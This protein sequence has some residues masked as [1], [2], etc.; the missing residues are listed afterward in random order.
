MFFIVIELNFRVVNKVCIIISVLVLIGS[1]V[2]A[3]KSSETLVIHGLQKIPKKTLVHYWGKPSS[4]LLTDH[5]KSINKSIH[6]L[7]Q[8]G[9]FEDVVVTDQV[10]HLVVSVKERPVISQVEFDDYDALKEDKIKEWLEE[11]GLEKSSFYSASKRYGLEEKIKRYYESLGRFET[12][13]HFTVAPEKNNQVSLKLN[14]DESSVSSIQNIHINGAKSFSES[15]V[16]KRWPIAAHHFFS[17][18]TGTDDYIK[19]NVAQ[20]VVLLEQFYHDRGYLDYELKSKKVNFNKEDGQ[21]D[22]VFNIDEGQVYTINKCVVDEGAKQI[23]A[24]EVQA[25]CSD[26]VNKIYKEKQISEK[27]AALS[28]SLEKEHILNY[29]YNL[30]KKINHKKH[31]VAVNIS[32]REAQ[33]D[34]VRHINIHGNNGMSDLILRHALGFEEAGV[35]S[36]E[37]VKQSY[38]QLMMLGFVENI[39]FQPIPVPGQ[40]HLSDLD[41]SLQEKRMVSMTFQVGWGSADGFLGNIGFNNGNFLGLGQK[42]SFQLKY[43]QISQVLSFDYVD[44]YYNFHHGSRSYGFYLK[45]QTPGKRLQHTHYIKDATGGYINYG[46]PLNRYAS[47]NYGAGINYNT[48]KEFQSASAEIQS[49]IQDHGDSYQEY[50]VSGGFTYNTLN[51]RFFASKGQDLSANINFRLPLNKYS[52]SYYTFHFDWGLYQKLTH[53]YHEKDDFVFGFRYQFDYGNH[54]GQFKDYPFYANFYAG[55]LSSIKGFQAGSLGPKDSLGNVF[56]GNIAHFTEAQVLLP[57]R[58]FGDSFRVSYFVDA[59]QVYL[60]NMALKDI[61]MSTGVMFKWLTPLCPITMSYALPIKS[62]PGDLLDRFQIGITAAF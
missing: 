7:Y 14:L 43:S 19:D 51:R 44:P 45:R 25:A 42:L 29:Q 56:G 13:V 8:T 15:E 10:D 21:V 54:Y 58:W 55:G 57:E 37:K 60:K 17:F 2:A 20:A 36:Q 27:I 61:R 49:F 62:R 39:G 22:I 34:Y 9:F 48:I 26:M 28:R 53:F 31:T 32:K 4:Y 6:Q 46:Y 12:K 33:A 24:S 11:F 5:N 35:V 18:L 3:T 30:G 23:K 59:G 52:S 50:S 40:K 38:Q 47:F 1:S 16:Q 41:V